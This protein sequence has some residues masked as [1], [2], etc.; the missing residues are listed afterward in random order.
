MRTQ[1]SFNPQLQNRSRSSPPIPLYLGASLRNKNLEEPSFGTLER[2]LR[3]NDMS[4]GAVGDADR[5]GATNLNE[6]SMRQK[7]SVQVPNP[8][9]R[10]LFEL[11]TI[12]NELGKDAMTTV[13]TTL[14]PNSNR[15][16][17]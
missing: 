9:N 15:S 13:Q 10:V 16:L 8:E 11:T 1:E 17:K 2:S 5:S 6:Q 12:S 4:Y 3:A 14:I 7:R